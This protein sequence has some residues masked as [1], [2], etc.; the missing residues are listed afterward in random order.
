MN[1]ILTLE[2]VNKSFGPVQAVRDLTLQLAPGRIYGLLGRNGAGKTT[3]LNLINSRLYAQSG[4]IRLFGEPAVDNQAV[5]ARICYMPE[6][7]L[8]PDGMRVREMLDLAASFYSDFDRTYAD[9]LCQVFDL[10]HRKRYKALSRGYESILRIVIGLAARSELTIFDEPVLGL[11]AAGRDLF[12]RTLIQDY[13][14][15]P[16][17]FILST[18]LIDE[19]ADIFEEVMIIKDGSLIAFAP[20][21]ELRRKALVLSGRTDAVDGFVQTHGLNVL[22]KETIGQLSAVTVAGPL[23][24]EHSRQARAA[25]ID[26][27][28]VSLQ[29]VFIHLTQPS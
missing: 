8:F 20:V 21:D 27:D 1:T 13:S 26:L 11:D 6:K 12:Y 24:D 23:S 14:E 19:S 2:H 5:L 3:L 7:N 15:H 10:D 28:P 18:H 16:R 9:R 29:K 25:G 4:T 17:T 22:A